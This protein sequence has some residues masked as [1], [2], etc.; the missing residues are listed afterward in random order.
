VNLVVDGR[1]GYVCLISGELCS[2]TLISMVII[3]VLAAESTAGV[4]LCFAIGRLKL[5]ATCKQDPIDLETSYALFMYKMTDRDLYCTAVV[6]QPSHRVINES[7]QMFPLRL[8]LVGG[9]GRAYG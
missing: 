4:D 5:T 3:M 7:P 6:L 1:L 9:R 8:L 2:Y